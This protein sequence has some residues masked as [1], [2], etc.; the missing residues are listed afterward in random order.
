[1]HDSLLLQFV[2]ARSLSV[3]ELCA[4]VKCTWFAPASLGKLAWLIATAILF[5]L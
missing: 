3:R 2:C 4:T 1:M 5:V